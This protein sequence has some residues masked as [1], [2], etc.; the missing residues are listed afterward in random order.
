[1][2]LDYRNSKHLVSLADIV[3]KDTYLNQ[4][5]TPDVNYPAG[6]VSRG[7]MCFSFFGM[8]GYDVKTKMNIALRD[9]LLAGEFTRS[10]ALA[11][12]A[13]GIDV[14]MKIG[15][16]AAAGY[17]PYGSLMTR[18]LGSMVDD[19]VRCILNPT[20]D[21]RIVIYG[22]AFRFQPYL[23]WVRNTATFK[24]KRFLVDDAESAWTTINGSGDATYDY[25][26]H[27]GIDLLS[28]DDGFAPTA[29]HD[30]L[31][32][33][34]PQPASNY[35]IYDKRLFDY[36]VD[37]VAMRAVDA[38]GVPTTIEEA[39]AFMTSMMSTSALTNPLPI[40]MHY[41]PA[42]TSVAGKQMRVSNIY[43]DSFEFP[44]MLGTGMDCSKLP[45]LVQET[46]TIKSSNPT[47]KKWYIPWPKMMSEALAHRNRVYMGFSIDRLPS[48]SQATG[49][50]NGNKR[51]D[52]IVSQLER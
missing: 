37:P 38:S 14:G 44:T 29:A 4:T 18:I 32:D 19:R 13:G 36:V 50:L 15:A 5:D 42:N 34:F 26:A 17:A 45:E 24:V 35:Q 2:S 47:G 12:D 20:E 51:R 3:L 39:A 27:I 41:W 43:M 11:A 16:F 9:T 28:D 49:R 1:M 8:V 30:L 48:P 23:K 10:A 40:E 25:T 6:F 21:S 52:S 22:K 46:V 33:A 31:S 7:S